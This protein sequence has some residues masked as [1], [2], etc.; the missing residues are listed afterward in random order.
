MK[1]SRSGTNVH[2]LRSK[3]PTIVSQVFGHD[4]ECLNTGISTRAMKFTEC[5]TCRYNEIDISGTRLV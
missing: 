3:S 1:R 5:Q 4:R 2:F